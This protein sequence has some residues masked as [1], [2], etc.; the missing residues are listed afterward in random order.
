MKYAGIKLGEPLNFF[1]HFHRPVWSPLHWLTIREGEGPLSKD[2]LD[3]AIRGHA[4][5]M[6][7]HSLDDHLVDG[8][9]PVSHLSL[10]IRSEAWRRL[11]DA[12][13]SLCTDLP[14]GIEM[15]RGLIDDYYGGITEGET[16]RNIEGYCDLF[17]KQL[18][19]GLVMPLLVARKTGCDDR[20]MSGL[21]GATESFGIAWR[22][23]DDI[24]DLEA[25][26]A[27]GARSA[28]YVCLDDKGR[29]LWDERGQGTGKGAEKRSERIC[30]MV[31]EGKI[32]ETIAGRIVAEMDNA[33]ALA[34]G[35][36]LRGL[37][38]EYRAL[39]GPVREWVGDHR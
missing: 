5:A 11:N 8:S 9:I 10:L 24:Q 35:I 28:V 29:T 15:A 33:A 22:L 4:M 12:I 34:D 20:F 32:I 26:M 19:T 14:G 23:L 25:D 30:A 2:C 21:R 36:G 27:G 1:S 16:P 6:T 18:A 7:L 31:N 39:A 37:G 38:D 13:D 17:R 3:H